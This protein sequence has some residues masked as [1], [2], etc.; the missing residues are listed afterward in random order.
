[1]AGPFRMLTKD[2]FGVAYSVY[3]Y[4]HFMAACPYTRP[5]AVDGVLPTAETIGSR[6][7][8]YVTEVYVVMRRDE[9]KGT[10]ARKLRDW[11]LTDE[12]QAVV[13][14]S[15]YVPLPRE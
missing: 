9:P 10:N 12:G 8:P 4:E 3:F 15:G 6:K 7:Y 2:Q 11:L 14:E 13:A 5:L 1:M